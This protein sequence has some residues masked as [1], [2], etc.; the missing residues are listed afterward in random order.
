MSDLRNMMMAAGGG[1]AP[2]NVFFTDFSG[3]TLGQPDPDW[4]V[5]FNVGGISATVE[6]VGVGGSN[7]LQTIGTAPANP[8]ALVWDTPGDVFDSDILLRF[9]IFGGVSGYEILER[10]SGS[11]A[12]INTVA[13]NPTTSGFNVRYWVNSGIP[14]FAN[15]PGGIPLSTWLWSR[16][17]HIGNDYKIKF[18]LD[19]GAEPG[20]WE[21]ENTNAAVPGPGKF[22]VGTFNAPAVFVLDQATVTILD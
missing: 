16:V 10:A 17:Q 1:A 8:S 4:S 11:D 14:V 22:G 9:L 5:L 13:T 3:K 12:D 7:A 18:W 19:G 6:A 21:Y 2:S 20:A 15:L